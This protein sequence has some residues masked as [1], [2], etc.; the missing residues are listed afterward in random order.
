MLFEYEFPLALVKGATTAVFFGYNHPQESRTGTM[1]SNRHRI[2]Y[3]D[4]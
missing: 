3:E 4:R 1:V 2:T